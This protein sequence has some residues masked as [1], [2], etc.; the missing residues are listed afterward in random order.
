MA[1]DFTN[2]QQWV[3]ESGDLLPEAIL[4]T[5]TLKHIAV[6]TNVS[7]GTVSLNVFNADV[8]DAPRSCDWNPSGSVVF[9]QINVT[10]ED[11]QIKQEMCSLDARNFYT[12]QRMSPTAQGQDLPFENII[13]DYYLTGVQKNIED[14]IGTSLASSISAANGAQVP[15]GAAALTVANAVDQLNDLYDA[16]DP[17][18]Q[19]R[20]DIKIVMSPSNYRI[21]VRAMVASDLIHYNFSDGS[22]D[23]YLPGTDA[24]LVKNSGLVGQDTIVAFSGANAIFATGLLD[25]STKFNLFYD[26]GQDT[27]KATMFYRQGLGVYDVAK[28]ATNGL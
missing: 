18:I 10:V 25:D 19:Q 1:L 15:A 5:D 7:A 8:T 23:V 4:S 22:G 12:A 28:M 13:A 24:L 17:A 6:Q 27:L 3:D 11:R 16:L 26:Q 21:A 2:L 20:S 14:F 9:D